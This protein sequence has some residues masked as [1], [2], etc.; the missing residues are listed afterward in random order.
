MHRIIPSLLKSS[1]FQSSKHPLLSKEFGGFSTQTFAENRSSVDPVT[2][3][4]CFYSRKCQR[5]FGKKKFNHQDTLDLLQNLPS[6]S[7]DAPTD[8]SSDEEIP[9]NYLLEFS[10]DS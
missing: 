2:E 9:A 8:D 1:K 5:V 7:S 6:E 3:E 4:H 10:L